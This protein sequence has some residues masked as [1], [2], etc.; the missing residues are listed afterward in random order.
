MVTSPYHEHL[1]PGFALHAS[2]E[3]PLAPSILSNS[4]NLKAY[5]DLLLELLTNIS[6]GF[7]TQLAAKFS[8][9]RQKGAAYRHLQR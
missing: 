2:S 9:A 5:L 4:Y 3:S 8:R 6:N 7:P 1:D